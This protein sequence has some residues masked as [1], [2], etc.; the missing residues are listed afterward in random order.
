M[1][2]EKAISSQYF[3]LNLKYDTKEMKNLNLFD[4]SDDLIFSI[5]NFH[6]LYSNIIAS[7][8][9]TINT[10]RL[11]SFLLMELYTTKQAAIQ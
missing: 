8:A 5:F 1:Y 7:P 4:K 9:F 10:L 11:I 3:D 6:F 2:V